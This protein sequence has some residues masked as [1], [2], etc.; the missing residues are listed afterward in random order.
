MTK[1]ASIQTLFAISPGQAWP[2][3][4][5][6]VKMDVSENGGT[7][8]SSYFNRVFRYK[9]SILGFPYFWKHPK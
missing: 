5:G 1:K 7:P 8:K 9:P 3:V 4:D 2:N 6:Q